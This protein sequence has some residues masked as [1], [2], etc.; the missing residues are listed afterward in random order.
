MS[1]PRPLWPLPS[2][3]PSPAGELL[4]WASQWQ[5]KLLKF[6]KSTNKR[7]S[8]EAVRS[9]QVPMCPACRRR[10]RKHFASFS[11][12]GQV[13]N[14]G[15]E[16]TDTALSCAFGHELDGFIT[17]PI[18]CNF[19]H[20]FCLQWSQNGAEV[21]WN[22]WFEKVEFLEKFDKFEKC[23]KFE[24][25]EKLKALKRLKILKY[26]KFEVLKNFTSLKSFQN[27][28]SLNNLERKFE[29]L[30]S[31]KIWL[32]E[33]YEI[34]ERMK[35]GNLENLKSLTSLESSKFWKVSKFCKFETLI[36]WKV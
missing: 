15:R 34:F 35:F 18:I 28:K 12:P 10:T 32:F 22:E 20:F 36:F 7:S 30:K 1:T 16:T 8:F 4:T 11:K 13:C 3:D 29:T 24:K 26:W 17:A 5:P 21:L 23:E 14:K 19:E 2:I 25:S 6:H 33:K 27:L 31:S 9:Q